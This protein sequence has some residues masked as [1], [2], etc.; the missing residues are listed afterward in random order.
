[1]VACG[2]GSDCSRRTPSLRHCPLPRPPCVDRDL[3]PRARSPVSFHRMTP[4]VTS[5][6]PSSSRARATTPATSRASA[7]LLAQAVALDPRPQ[8]VL[9]P[10][11]GAERLLPR[12]RG[13]RARRDRWPARRAICTASTATDRRSTSASASTRCGATSCTTARSTSRSARRCRSCVT[14]I[15]RSSCRRTGCSTRSASSSAAATSARSTRRGGAPR[16]WCARMPG[17]A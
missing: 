4:F 12:G 6:S 13:A 7:T 10:G 5:L 14:S 15:A 8:L 9:L 11:D 1:M 16:S 17:T 2:R 3:L